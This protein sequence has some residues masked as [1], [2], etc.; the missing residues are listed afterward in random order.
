[1][2]KVCKEGRTYTHKRAYREAN[3]RRQATQSLRPTSKEWLWLE[4]DVSERLGRRWMGDI[5]MDR[6]LGA[7][8]W[9]EK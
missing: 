6:R 1:M 4:D 7:G 3:W 9:K 5:T 8:G 2:D